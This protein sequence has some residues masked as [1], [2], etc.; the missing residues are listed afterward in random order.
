MLKW[1]I[2]PGDSSQMM[3]N[4]TYTCCVQVIADCCLKPIKSFRPLC[5]ITRCYLKRCLL[6]EQL[7]EGP[8]LSQHH[9]RV[10]STSITAD[11]PALNPIKQSQTH[12]YTNPEPQVEGRW[13][14]K[15]TLPGL[16][17]ISKVSKTSLSVFYYNV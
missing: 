9:D 1:L 8:L 11:R 6:L 17:V 10:L 2:W 12:L 4:H 5:D 7:E 16:Q 13:R 3:R 14:E 15:K